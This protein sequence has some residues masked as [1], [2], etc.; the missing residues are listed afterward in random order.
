MTYTG[1]DTVPLIIMFS[2]FS[3]GWASCK[4]MRKSGVNDRGFCSAAPDSIEILFQ[5]ILFVHQLIK[6]SFVFILSSIFSIL[7]FVGSSLVAR[8]DKKLQSPLF[9]SH[10]KYGFL[11]ILSSIFFISAFVRSSLVARTNQKNSKPFVHKSIN[12]SPR[13]FPFQLLSDRLQHMHGTMGNRVD[14]NPMLDW[15]QS[16]N[17]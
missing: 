5:D 16:P 8:T 13:F 14:L 4:R 7:A 15:R 1:R 9:T 3:D 17:F 11:I 2:L 6:Y 10:S 12:S